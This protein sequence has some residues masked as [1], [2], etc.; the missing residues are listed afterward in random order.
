MVLELGFGNMAEL[1][2]PREAIIFTESR[3][4]QEY[5]A[6]FLSANGYAGKLAAFSGTNISDD[7]TRTYQEWMAANKGSDR[8]TRSPQVDRRTALI[9][10]FRRMDRKG[11]TS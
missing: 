2:A 1:H 5:L 7:S 3:R 6:R 11:E 9:D 10:H 4:T 8:I